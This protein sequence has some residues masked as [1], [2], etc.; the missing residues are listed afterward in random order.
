MAGACLVPQDLLVA[1]QGCLVPAPP[2]P[3]YSAGAALSNGATAS[4]TATPAGQQ[5]T[6]WKRSSCRPRTA[7]MLSHNS[8]LWQTHEV[9]DKCRSAAPRALHGPAMMCAGPYRLLNTTAA[10][11]ILIVT[12]AGVHSRCKTCALCHPLPKR[13]DCPHLWL[14][15]DRQ[16]CARHNHQFPAQVHTRSRLMCMCCLLA[17]VTDFVTVYCDWCRNS[18]L[19]D[20]H[21]QSEDGGKLVACVLLTP[22]HLGANC[23]LSGS[24]PATMYSLLRLPS[25]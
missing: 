13:S 7:N 9:R 8:H 24:S 18:L 10:P 6:T 1:P 23:A 15:E 11:T 22:L 21:L 16:P 5:P 17:T 20:Q 19:Q 2:S 12:T 3:Q 25:R 14:Q 4:C